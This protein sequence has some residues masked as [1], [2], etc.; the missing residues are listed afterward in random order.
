MPEALR[1]HLGVLRARLEQQ[2]YDAMVADVTQ[3]GVA[4]RS[5]WGQVSVSVV[6]LVVPVSGSKQVSAQAFSLGMLPM[7]P[8]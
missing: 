4:S 7:Q 6:Q 1:R 3:V 5:M 2:Q 8:R